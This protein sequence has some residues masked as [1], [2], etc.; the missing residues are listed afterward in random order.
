MLSSTMSQVSQ[1]VVPNPGTS[2][3]DTV[4]R[5]VIDSTITVKLTVFVSIAS[6]LQPFLTVYQTNRPMVPFIADDLSE[7]LK[8]LLKRYTKAD[9]LKDI[10]MTRLSVLAQNDADE[11]HCPASKIDIGIVAEQLLKPIVS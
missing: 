5:S 9:V 11:S 7:L 10:S 2:S 8:G 4:A 6:Q 1:N 3:Y